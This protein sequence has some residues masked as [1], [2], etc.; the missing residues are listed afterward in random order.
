M[1]INGITIAR[2]PRKEDNKSHEGF[3]QLE[4]TR[5]RKQVCVIKAQSQRKSKTE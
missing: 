5:N 2:N 1:Q 3:V 4:Q